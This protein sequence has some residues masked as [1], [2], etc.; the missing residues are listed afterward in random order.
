MSQ[1]NVEIL[2]R[3]N[4]AFNRGDVEG[5]LVWCSEDLEV[6][7]L[8]PAPDMPPVAQGKDQVL[9]LMAAWTDAFEDFT[10]A[11]EGYFEIDERHVGCHVHYHGRQRGMGLEVDF[12]TVDVWELRNGKIVRGTLGYPDPQSA[13][14]AT[15]HD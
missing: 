6:E 13:L 7:D 8:N 11:I 4:E 2:R 5:F 12:K 14:A 9:A 3:A 1:Q 10:G 15:T